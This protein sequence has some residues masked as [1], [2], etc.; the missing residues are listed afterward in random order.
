M[1]DEVQQQEDDQNLWRAVYTADGGWGEGTAFADHLSVAA[2]ALAEANGTLY[3]AHRGARQGGD[4]QLPLRWTSFTP[5]TLVPLVDALE[6]ARVPLP[7]GATD[8]E[9]Q[10]W[11]E[12]VTAAGEALD[13]ARKWTPDAYVDWVRS[14]E[15]PALVN[16]NGTLRMVFT[17]V[18]SM[19][20][21]G[22]EYG[23]SEY[24][25]QQIRATSLWE[26]WLEGADGNPKWVKPRQIL[27]DARMPL[28]PG[29]AVFNGA[30]HLVFVDPHSERLQH[31]VR[32][33]E[34]EWTPV[35]TP[36]ARPYRG[37]SLFEDNTFTQAAFDAHGWPGSVSLA[38]HDGQLHALYRG[39]PGYKL[40]VTLRGKILDHTY[41][42]LV[43]A[44]FD[45]TT[46]SD[47]R[48]AGP[49][50]Q[51]GYVEDYSSRRGGALASYGGKLHT[52]FPSP[53]NKLC[54]GTWTQEAGWSAPLTLEEHDSSNSPALLPFREGPEGLEREVL[55]LVHRGVDRYVPPVPPVP[56]APPS[57]EDVAERGTPV[58]G[59]LLTAYG[60]RDWSR[61]EHQFT[62]TPATMKDGKP[63]LIV[64]FEAWA[65]Y[66][67]VWSWYRERSG[68]KYEPRLKV[69]FYLVEEDPESMVGHAQFA[70]SAGDGYWR[71]EKVFT[72]VKPGVDYKA[73]LFTGK[74]E[75]TGGYWWASRAALQ[76][77]SADWDYEQYTRVSGFRSSWATIT[78]PK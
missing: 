67:W 70:A 59:K 25:D 56:P 48:S 58:T 73:G 14:A 53:D 7:E 63:G 68:G 11:E 23:G 2:P 61:L 77:S 37:R 74:T 65:Q 75:K 72:N 76:D 69:D 44:A 22:S 62:L 30:V 32:G 29:L 49:K 19:D 8:A 50:N 60:D 42:P 39:N 18:G 5:A 41:G 78:L 31:L 43:Y 15:T 12:A 10:K 64:T 51:E 47:A 46:W 45:G 71:F 13:R 28:A 66:Y 20:D 36:E 4:K 17:R 6:Q 9:Q 33:A 52:V 16:D 21:D 26:A 34:G 24:G 3:C 1:A 55:L 38:V 54:H 27:V 35:A 40:P 57:L